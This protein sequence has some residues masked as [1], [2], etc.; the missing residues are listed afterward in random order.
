MKRLK[1]LLVYTAVFG[2]RD[3]IRLP[4]ADAD[5]DFAAFT[6][7]P[8]GD[9]RVVQVQPP[10][11]GDPRRSSR[12]IKILLPETPHRYSLW[13]DGSVALK[14]SHLDHLVDRHLSGGTPL[15]AFRHP[16]RTCAYQEASVC[17]SAR[18]DDPGV[19]R[20]QAASY[21]ATGMPENTGLAELTVILRDHE[22][23]AEFSRTWWGEVR[24]RS[25]RDQI[26]FP[27]VV[28]KTG[29][30]WTMFE[31]SLRENSHFELM[32]HN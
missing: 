21:R 31:G 30:R 25:C 24:T 27:F 15:A 6:D 8:A 19:I 32:P 5:F 16:S 18:L 22:R 28:W 13:I 23:S 9:P 26:S 29:L 10:V 20:A 1:R 3:P 12:A 4:P 2:G 11:P 14:T 17:L 7:Q